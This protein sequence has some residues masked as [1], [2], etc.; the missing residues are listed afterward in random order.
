MGKLC[1]WEGGEVGKLCGLRG[2]DVGMFCRW[3]IGKVVEVE[4][5]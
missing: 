4:R 2:K 1:S 3:R 5:Q